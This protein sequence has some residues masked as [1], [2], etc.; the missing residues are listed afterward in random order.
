[1]KNN[2]GENKAR[3]TSATAKR[4]QAP[5]ICLTVNLLQLIEHELGKKGIVNKPKNGN[6]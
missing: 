1:V 3:A 6:G 4:M 5:F 2:L